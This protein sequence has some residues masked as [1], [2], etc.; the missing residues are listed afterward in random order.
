MEIPVQGP[1]FALPIKKKIMIIEVSKAEQ[2][3]KKVIN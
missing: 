1:G 3:N 2:T